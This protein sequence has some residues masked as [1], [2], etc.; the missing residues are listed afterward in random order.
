MN[1]LEF[2]I[3]DILTVRNIDNLT[4][5]CYGF[6]SKFNLEKN[7]ILLCRNKKYW[8]HNFND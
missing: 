2:N 1:N 6:I 8:T 3:G 5:F 4:I 7:T